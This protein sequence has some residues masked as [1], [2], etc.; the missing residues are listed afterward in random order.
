[1]YFFFKSLSLLSILH[2]DNI[3]SAQNVV[4][5]WTLA[6]LAIKAPSRYFKLSELF[7]L[8]IRLAIFMPKS[9]YAERLGC[10]GQHSPEV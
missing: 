7:T 1:M 3:K 5:N 8:L 2:C 4:R 9:R 10:S 6:E